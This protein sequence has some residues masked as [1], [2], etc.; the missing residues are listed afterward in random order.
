MTDSEKLQKLEQD[1]KVLEMKVHFKT[2]MLILG[3]LGFFSL[4]GT[5]GKKVRKYSTKL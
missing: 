3:F 2:L 5:T 1:M 4:F